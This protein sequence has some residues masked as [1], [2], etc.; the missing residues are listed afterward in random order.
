MGLSDG[1][2][3]FPIGLAVL[4]QYRR[5]TDRHPAA[6][7]PPYQPRRRSKYALCI[8]ASRSKNRQN[9]LAHCRAAVCSVRAG[10]VGGGLF[11]VGLSYLNCTQTALAVTML[12]MATTLTGVGLSGFFINH[13]DI[14]P[15]YAGTLMGVSNGIA[16]ASGF[17]APLVAALLTTDVR[18]YCCY[19]IVRNAEASLADEIESLDQ[20]C[21]V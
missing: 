2:K 10:T 18:D 8:S 6:S 17:V 4:I 13:M 7:Q 15:P 19:L 3:S 12:T 11:L 21:K 9:A 14:A 20:Y 1:R 16:A 5:V